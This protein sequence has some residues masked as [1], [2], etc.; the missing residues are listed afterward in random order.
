MTSVRDNVQEA[1]DMTQYEMAQPIVL[2]TKLK[3]TK[4][5][6]IGL[7]RQPKT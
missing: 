6:Q 7:K 5:R 1:T 3:E 2:D 4:K